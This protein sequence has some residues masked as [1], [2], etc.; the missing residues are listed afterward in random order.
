M[1]EDDPAA[2]EIAR[3][4]SELLAEVLALTSPRDACRAAAD[5]DAVWS[6]FLGDFCLVTDKFSEVVELLHGDRVDICGKIPCKMHSGSSDYAAYLVFV[7][8]MGWLWSEGMHQSASVGGRRS[9]RQVCLDISNYKDEVEVP[10]DG[11]VFLPQERADGWMELELGEFYNEECSN[12]DFVVELKGRGLLPTRGLVVQG[13]EIRPKKSGRSTI[14]P[15]SINSHHQITRARGGA[16][17]RSKEESSI[18]PSMADAEEDHPAA[19]EI[20]RLPTELLVEVLALTTPRDACRAAAVC[21]E[22]RAAAE[23]DAFW[24]RFLPLYIPLLADGELSP[25]LPPPPSAKGLFLRL[26]AAPLLFR[27]EL[28]SMWLDRESGDKCYMLSARALH[29]SWGDTP[30]YWE[31][32]PLADSRFKEGAR[33]RT[34]CWLEI[35]GKIPS[36][37]LSLN[38]IY[39]AYLVYKL[40]DKSSRLDYPFQ[41][42]TVS[43]GGSKTIHHVGIAERR[44]KTRYPAVVVLARDVE[45]PQKRDDSWIELKLGELYNEEGDDGEVCISLMETKGGNWKSGLVVQGI[46]IRPKK[47]PP[48]RSLP[49][50]P[51]LTTSRSCKEEMF[52]TDGLTSMWLDKETGFKCYMLSARALQIE[53]Y[54]ANW[55]WISLTG[56]SRFSEVVELVQGYRVEICCKIPCKMLSGNSNYAAHIVFVVAEDSYELVSV[57]DA[58]VSVGGRQSTR[59][60]RLDTYNYK[61]EIEVPQDGSAFVPRERTDGWLELELGEFYNKEGNYE[62]ESL[63]AELV[64]FERASRLGLRNGANDDLAEP[65]S[66]RNHVLALTT[67]RDACRTAAVCREFLASADSDAVWSRFLPGGDFPLLADG[68]LE[69]SLSLPPPSTKGL[70]L[71]LSAAPLLLPDELKSMWLDRESGH[72]CYML[73]ARALQ[74]YWGDTPQYWEWIPIADSRF[75]EC[76]QL[77]TE[78]HAKIP[79]KML[80]LNTNY[81]AYLVYKLADGSRGLDFPFQEA[82]VSIGGSK[83]ICQVGIAERRLKTRYPTAVVLARDVEHPQKRDDSWIELKLGE[84]YNEEGDD[85][86]VCISL[87]ETK[88]GNWKSG[89]VVQGIEIRPKKTPPFRSLPCSHEKP[90]YPRLTTS[91]SCMEEM[92]LPDGLMSM[93]LDKETGFK[94]YMLSARALNIEDYPANWCWIS[95]TGGCRFSKV[96]ELSDGW[97]LDIHAKIPCKMLSGNSNYAV[98]IVF[99]V[100]EDSYGLDAIL[101]ASVSVGKNQFSTHQVCLD[102]SSCL[103]EDDYY[104]YDKIE[105]PQDGSVLLPQERA[106]CW[107]ELELGEFYNDEGDNWGEVC[108]SLVEPKEGRWLGKG[109]LVVQGIEIRPKNS[110]PILRERE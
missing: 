79:S 87:M 104:Y 52:L 49:V 99:V 64:F 8:H 37:M 93:W 108:L 83:T 76:A 102:S 89:L 32:I 98:Y 26:S 46:E 53:N 24:S 54:V 5:S 16:S 62:D 107:M 4:P 36:K 6:R 22:F 12:E 110:G 30:Q 106:D 74:I 105:V 41:E 57:W 56:G 7:I 20:A 3:L 48:L 28:M 103:G 47:T 2:C 77:R 69:P 59:L 11:S 39:A 10:Q 85:G 50:Y 25:V 100:A 67:P 34:V 31:W 81:A 40:D 15:P 75:K 38:T 14:S 80:S 9:T 42:A 84:L 95:L 33:L 72:K 23:S 35:H 94:C 78:I 44:L 29:I 101:D 96:V 97:M 70:F 68:E 92:F 71:R 61:G 82:S 21:R 43:I 1:H 86:E 13:I 65:S 90:A 55:R 73:S 91:R 27:D 51:R 18:H 58:T 45:H 17:N 63:E 60:V 109:G 66:I 88:G 19:C